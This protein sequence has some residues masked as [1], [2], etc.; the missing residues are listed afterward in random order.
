MLL[1]RTARLRSSL[2][3]FPSETYGSY[4]SFMTSRQGTVRGTTITLDASVPPLEGKRVLVLI[5]PLEESEKELSRETQAQLWQA[6]VKSGPQGPIEDE[7]E[8]EF[9]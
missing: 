5:E 7:A 3:P 1:N 9:P 2:L 6:W 4:N 8:A